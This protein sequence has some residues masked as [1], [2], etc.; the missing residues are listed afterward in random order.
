MIRQF[1]VM[2]ALLAVGSCTGW[3]GPSVSPNHIPEVSATEAVAE[4]G[5]RLELDSAL[6]AT[7]GDPASHYAMGFARVLCAAVFVSG[8]EAD[9]AA[10][11][12]RL[13]YL[14]S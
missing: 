4:R 5:Q 6:A 9:F 14:A 10:K 1:A 13:L 3:Q 2:C 12:C 7:P 8:L 11:K